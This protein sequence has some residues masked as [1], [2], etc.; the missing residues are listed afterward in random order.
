MRHIWL[1]VSHTDVQ[2]ELRQGREE[3][4]PIDELSA[5]VERLLTLPLDDPEGHPQAQREAE[6]FLD[7]AAALPIEAAYRFY[8]PSDLAG[9]RAERPESR[10]SLPEL[11]TAPEV[12]LDQVYGAW[13]GRVCGCLLGKPVEGWKRPRMWGYLR[14]TGRFPLDG[15]FSL[16]APEPVLRTYDV[17]PERCFIETVSAMPEDD[18]TNYTTT[19]LAITARHGRGFT[20]EHVAAFWMQE[21]PILHTCTAERVAYR[22]FTLGISPP[23]SAVHRNPYREWI[24]AQIRADFWGYLAA[25]NPELAAEYAWRDACIS[26]VK[27]GIYGEMWA[28]AMIAAAF[29]SRD[30]RIILEAGLGQIPR[31]CRLAEGVRRVMSDHDL[32]VDYNAAVE[33]IHARW[34]ENRA[35]D[36]C[37]TI[38]N[39]EIVAL[40]LLYGKGEFG[41]TL[42]RAVQ[43]CFD[44]DCNGA[45]VGSIIGIIQGAAAIPVAWHAPFQDT[46]LTGVAGYHRVGLRALAEETCRMILTDSPG[47]Q[48]TEGG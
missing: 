41:A 29:V 45:T 46:L 2:T 47:C 25:G 14:D 21:I 24:G 28:A 13:R 33:N 10:P 20:P 18:D 37:H 22:N 30:I 32:G 34:D 19:G 11:D 17:R 44:T 39:A 35:H 38:S 36:W 8:E 4:K 6:M 26:H 23:N 15:Y 31:R 43:P 42:T 16:D 40:G 9:I 7:R 48:A 3:G 12:L 27:N 1:Y 5:A